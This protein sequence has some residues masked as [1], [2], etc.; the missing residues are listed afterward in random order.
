MKNAMNVKILSIVAACFMVLCCFAGCSGK[1]TSNGSNGGNNNNRNVTATNPYPTDSRGDV[2]GG[3]HV[4]NVSK[5]NVDFVKDS[6]SDYVIVLPSDS[7]YYETLAAQEL[8]TFMEK[9]TGVYFPVVR[10]GELTQEQIASND[11]KFISIGNTAVFKATKIALDKK[12]F[13]DGGFIIKTVGN[14]L[15][16][17][18]ATDYCTGTLYAAYE[19]LHQLVDFEVYTGDVITYNTVSIV[20][21]PNFDIKDIPD[22]NW[23]VVNTGMTCVST[24]TANR[25]RMNYNRSASP[26]RFQMTLGGATHHNMQRLIPEATYGA[27]HPNWF[28]QNVLDEKEIQHCYTCKGD[29]EEFAAFVNETVENLKKE[30]IAQPYAKFVNLG[31]ADAMYWCDCEACSDTAEKYGGANSATVILWMNEV[32]DTYY[33]WLR[34]AYPERDMTL[35]IFAYYDT[36]EP[37]AKQ[38]ENGEWEAVNG[39]RL[40]NGVTVLYAPIEAN[41]IDSLYY[42]D[43]NKPDNNKYYSDVIKSWRAVADSVNLWIYGSNYGTTESWITPYNA[44][45]SIQDNYKFA[46]ENNIF[47]MQY[48]RRNSDECVNHVGFMNLAAYLDSKFAW[49][50]NAD[51]NALTRN[52]FNAVYGPA[53]DKMLA[54]FYAMRA[55]FAVIES[56]PSFSKMRETNY[57]RKEYW[58]EAL[59]KSYIAMCDEALTAIEPVQKTDKTAYLRYKDSITLESITMRYLLIQ[60]YGSSYPQSELLQMKTDFKMDALRLGLTRTSENEKCTMG[61]L[62]TQWGV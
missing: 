37:P 6:T 11:G 21:L 43:A 28:A 24:V 31:Q 49:N 51:Y 57:A 30:T 32:S 4:Y 58:P 60:F 39:L 53:A 16:L 3:I 13:G 52:Y 42:D 18:G 56:D 54:Y 19:L 50:V 14:R 33:K 48:Q 41:R 36:K 44:F 25:M 20:K 9:A 2:E 10:D 40:K 27:V 23:R 5:T 15:I 7:D 29:K 46:K 34:E 1:N 26:T 17:T 12:E 22:F 61:A 59:L 45:N 8:N 55:Q 35:S 47:W 38:N 62:F